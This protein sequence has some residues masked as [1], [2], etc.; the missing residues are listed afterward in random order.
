MNILFEQWM[1]SQGQ[2]KESNLFLQLVR[3]KSS[4]KRGARAWL[5]KGE[6]VQRYGCK[7][8]AEKIVQAKERHARLIEEGKEEGEVQVRQ[9]PDS[10][11]A[12]PVV[13]VISSF[14]F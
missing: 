11:D 12:R 14:W 9:H 6:L 10:D 5:T 2:W 3:T 1:E 13:L 4:R 7:D 8:T